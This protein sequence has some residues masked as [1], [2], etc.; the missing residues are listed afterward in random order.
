MNVNEPIIARHIVVILAATAIPT[1][2][3]LAGRELIRSWLAGGADVGVGK[4]ETDGTGKGGGLALEVDMEEVRWM[5]VFGIAVCISVNV[6]NSIL[7]E[8]DSLEEEGL[9]KEECT[10]E[11][12]D[13]LV[14][15]VNSG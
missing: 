5:T 6:L 15:I 14:D 7:E 13:M 12:E 9:V 11:E 4:T 8:E 10:V 3:P 1:T 2:A